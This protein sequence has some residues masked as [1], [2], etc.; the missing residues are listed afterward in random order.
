MSTAAERVAGDL[1]RRV[2]QSAVHQ[3]SPFLDT[4]PEVETAFN[5]MITAL[6]A[7]LPIPT[8]ATELLMRYPSAES[9]NSVMMRETAL[10]M[11]S[12]VFYRTMT[13][14]SLRNLRHRIKRGDHPWFGCVLESEVNPDNPSMRDVYL[15]A[16]PSTALD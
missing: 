4:Q 1:V 12:P 13:V 9:V 6:G 11:Q 8:G 5:D 15:N 14:G 16:S 10:D 7:A 2:L 3:N